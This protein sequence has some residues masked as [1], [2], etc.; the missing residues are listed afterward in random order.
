M[1][2]ILIIVGVIVFLLIGI[3]SLYLLC[4]KLI[5]GGEFSAIFIAF[6]VISLLIPL[7]PEVQK[8]SIAGNSVTFK[9]AKQEVKNALRDL[10]KAQ[11]D[12]MRLL[13][14][15]IT[16]NGGLKVLES[17][18]SE[19]HNFWVLYEK[20]AHYGYEREL[21]SEILTTIESLLHSYVHLFTESSEK[22]K[23]TFS[24]ASK[25]LPNPTHIMRVIIDEKD[26][27]HTELVT[28]GLS[29]YQRLYELNHKLSNKKND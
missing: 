19:S 6:A 10:K 17:V 23:A 7:L 16:H 12:T 25:E 2:I 26:L 11:I 27:K 5:S 22:A 13:L 18:F 4:S 3:L 8:F 24:L 15:S 21:L 20:I 28:N 9:E 29:E 1:R 14:I